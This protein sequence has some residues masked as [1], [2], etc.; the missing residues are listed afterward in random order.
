MVDGSVIKL[1]RAYGHVVLSAEKDR[2]GCSIIE[3]KH[4]TSVSLNSSH[5]SCINPSVA[6][7]T[8]T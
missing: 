5:L 2:N 1:V 6:Q 4:M 8:L 3:Y 7:Q